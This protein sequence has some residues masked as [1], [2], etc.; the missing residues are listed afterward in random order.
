MALWAVSKYALNIA[1][2]VE[3]ARTDICGT[4]AKFKNLSTRV[5]TLSFQLLYV[6]EL[7]IYL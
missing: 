1:E 7:V 3:E 2:D 6:L 4:R 5:P